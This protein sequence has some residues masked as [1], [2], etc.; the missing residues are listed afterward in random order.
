ML[1]NSLLTASFD[2]VQVIEGTHFL[3]KYTR[4]KKRQAKHFLLKL[5]IFNKLYLRQIG[6]FI[7]F[8]NSEIKDLCP[9]TAI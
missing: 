2:I 7:I 4:E 6:A 1:C 5:L 8:F 3:I 9:K